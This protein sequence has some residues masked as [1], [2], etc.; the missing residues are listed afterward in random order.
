MVDPGT[1]AAPG[2][3][4]LQVDSGGPLELQATVAES[5]IASLHKG[6]KIAVTV[7]SL[8]ADPLN[9]SVTEIVPAADA[10]THSFQVKI[11][12]PAS[13]Q[14]RAGLSANAAIPAGTQQVVL[15]PRS[16]IVMRGSLASAYVLDAGGIAQLRYVTLGEAHGD[17]VEVLSGLSGADK[18]VDAPGDRELNGKHIEAEL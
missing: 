3:P 5:A 16:A 15:A 17:K 11:V 2:V 13:K 4:L 10:M 9:G 6:S 8:G 18:L 14:L 7:D 1:M 12:L